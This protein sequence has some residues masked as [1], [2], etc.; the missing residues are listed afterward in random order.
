M[1]MGNW[2]NGLVER[3]LWGKIYQTDGILPAHRLPIAAHF[4]VG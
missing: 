2:S 1:V 4:L 3:R